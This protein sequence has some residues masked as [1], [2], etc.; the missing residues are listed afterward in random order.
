MINMP[1]IKKYQSQFIIYAIPISQIIGVKY[2][3]I[4]P[5]NELDHLTLGKYSRGIQD[6]KYITIPALYIRK[7]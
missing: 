7:L 2:G 6:R 4:M 5:I 1:D 3:A